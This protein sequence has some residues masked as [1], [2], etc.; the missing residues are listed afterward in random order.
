MTTEDTEIL[1]ITNMTFIFIWTLLCFTQESVGQNVVV[2]QSAVKSVQLSQTVSIDCKVS[3]QVAHHSGSN[4]YLA[5]YH[6]KTG[7]APKLL[8][9]RTSDRFSGISSRF[10]G[11]GAGNGLD[12]TLTIS[13]V[14]AEDSGVYYC[15]SYHWINSQNFVSLW[16]TFGGG[17][18]LDVGRDVRPSL[19]V[20]PPSRE[21][22]QQGKATLM[23]LA[24]KGFPSDWSLS[25]KVD[26]SSS[27]SSSSSSSWEESRSPGVLQ[28]DG[29]YSWSST[30]RLPADQW[31][32]VGSVS[33]EATQGSQTPL[34]ETLRRDQCS[35]S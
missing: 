34:S 26:G 9:D 31:R 5:W 12:F 15:Q 8:I 7:E 3:R 22:L 29:L 11:S 27:S 28:E 35:Q 6:H 10:S 16:Y 32:K 33:C 24:N 4:Y 14:Q 1:L 17:T 30:L 23:C 21:E 2:T 20:L 19:T 13:G 25:W 18:R